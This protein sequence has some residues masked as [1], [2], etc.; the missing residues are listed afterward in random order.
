MKVF[1]RVLYLTLHLSVM[2]TLT[3]AAGFTVTTWRVDLKGLRMK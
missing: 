1:A 3:L 2:L